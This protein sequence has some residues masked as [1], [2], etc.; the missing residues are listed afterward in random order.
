MAVTK[1]KNIA[2][3]G[4]ITET[5]FRSV[6]TYHIIVLVTAVSVID[7]LIKLMSLC[8]EY[9]VSCTR[10]L[11]VLCFYVYPLWTCNSRTEGLKLKFGRSDYVIVIIL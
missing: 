8:C 7:L 10:I 4:A 5:V 3:F 9:V 1:T 11:S 6:S 2:S